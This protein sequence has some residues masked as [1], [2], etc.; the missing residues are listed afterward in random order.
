MR[1][2]AY[3]INEFCQQKIFKKKKSLHIKD[4]VKEMHLQ[5]NHILLFL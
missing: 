1:Y 5:C 2:I 4:F 3:N